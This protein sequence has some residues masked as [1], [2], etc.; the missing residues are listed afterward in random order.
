[1][2]QRN[3]VTN[4]T[5]EQFAA[6]LDGKAARFIC[7]GMGY[8][9]GAWA[10]GS[11]FKYT[12]PSKENV[13]FARAKG[14]RPDTRTFFYF[15]S[16]ISAHED[17]ATTY[18]ADR[19]LRPDGSHAD[20][21][22]AKYPLF[23]PREGTAF[24]KLQDEMIDLRYELLDLDG[25]YWD[26]IAYSA[27]KYDYSDNWDGYS[28]AI[29]PQTHRITRKIANVTLATLPWRTRA[30]KAIMDRGMLIGNG[31][32]QTRTFTRLHFPRF[33]ETAAITNLTRGQLYTPIALGDHLTERTPRDC[34]HSMVDGLDFGAVYYW[35]NDQIVA[36]EPTLTSYMFPITYVRMGQGFVIAEERILTNTS[37]MFGWDDDSDF[38]A[39][40]FDDTGKRIDT[41]DVPRRVVDGK[42][43][44]E[45]RIPGG[46]SVAL[47][48]Q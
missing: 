45:V 13:L 8:Y 40:V 19:L 38:E 23:V 16:Y 46:Y 7:S 26:E 10:H 17:D 29:D 4:M 9:K 20:Y 47:I 31:S 14:L 21:R 48:R 27:Y 44:A 34:Y 5:D 36:T 15:H 3:P 12:D 42:A 33:I 24:A 18:A 43:Y 28:A 41:V 1:M 2:W 25:I 35:Y 22:D 39:V 32:A 37:G 6:H 30:A 11:A